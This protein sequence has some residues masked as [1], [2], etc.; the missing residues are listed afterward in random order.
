MK[1]LKITL[2]DLALYESIHCDP[3]MMAHLG[4][5]WP[6]ERMP[7]KLQRDVEAVESGRSWV[8][9]IIP[10]GDS[11]SA[12]GSVCLWEN[13][14]NGELISEIGWMVLPAFQGRGLASEAVRAVLDQAR[15]EKRCDVIHAFPPTSNAS[16]NAI[17][18][19]MGFSL[20]E[21]CDLEYA[22]HVLRC[23][24]WRL[25]LCCGRRA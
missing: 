15:A 14:W 22:G 4:G 2:A 20:V 7:Q 18:R 19:K 5:P 9:K 16:S 1:L 24:H 21:E 6:R 12:A 23:N 17:S 25:D 10:E 8:F 13:S 3:K 11:E